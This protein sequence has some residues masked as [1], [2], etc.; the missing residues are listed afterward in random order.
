MKRNNDQRY[1]ISDAEFWSILRKNGA[2]YARTARAVKSEFG[3][4]ITRE[5]VYIRAN[6]HPEKLKDIHEENIDIAEEGLQDLM[7]T[8]SESIKYK[9]IEL[10]LK[11]KG[12]HRGYIQTTENINQNF[13]KDITIDIDETDN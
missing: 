3:V 10:F 9:A 5:A 11:T 8:G 4:D 6:R 1:K 13:N 7:R 2:L 12:K